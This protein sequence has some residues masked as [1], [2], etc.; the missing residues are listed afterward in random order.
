MRL[1]ELGLLVAA[2]IW[3]LWFQLTVNR[4]HIPDADYRAAASLIAQNAR[5]GDAVLL[6][7]WWTERARLFLPES[8]DTVGY[9]GSD[10]DDL[11]EHPRIWL[12]AAPDLPKSD[13]PGFLRGFGKDRAPLELEGKAGARRFGKLSV[14]LYRNDRARKVLWSAVDAL[15]SRVYVERPDGQ[16]E[17]CTRMGARFVCPGRL[18]VAAEWHEIFYQPRRCLFMHAP[19]GPD[20]LVAE[21]DHVPAAQTL[22][23][24]SGIIWEHAWKHERGLTPY[25]VSVRG[26]DGAVLGSLRIPVG[27]EGL[28]HHDISFQGAG[29]RTVSVAVHSDRFDERDGCVELTALGGRP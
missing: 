24:S 10:S 22:R 3:G 16:R 19:G 13:L 9:L 12:L 23:V 25:D 1:V 7:P 18:I 29:D 11:D 26:A 4:T 5:P 8:V 21:F 14:G 2:A 20:A 15:P 17:P 27:K 6:Y 28:L